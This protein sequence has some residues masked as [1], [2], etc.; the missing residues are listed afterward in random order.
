MRERQ[1]ER[2]RYIYREI[3]REREIRERERENEKER[4]RDNKEGG[5][6]RRGRRGM[7]PNLNTEFA[8]QQKNSLA[9]KRLTSADKHEQHLV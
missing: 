4:E 7:T 2:Y 8:T 1:R 3:E 5:R 6:K 9:D